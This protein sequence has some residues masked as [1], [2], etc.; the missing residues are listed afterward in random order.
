MLICALVIEEQ[1][2]TPSE[3]TAA[4][5]TAAPPDPVKDDRGRLEIALDAAEMGVWEWF[6]ADNRVIW[7]P[8]IERMHGLAPG[9]FKGQASDT[10]P[11]DRATVEEQVQR[12]L[13]ERTPLRVTYRIIR[14]DQSI[15]WLEAHGQVVLD[16]AGKPERVLGV[17]RDITERRESEVARV[18]LLASEVARADAERQRERLNGIFEGITDAFIV[19]DDEQRVVQANRA[20]AHLS[21]CAPDELI[22]RHIRELPLLRGSSI[23]RVISRA[24]KLRE[25]GVAEDYNAALDR[26]FESNVFP[27]DDGIS[28]YTRDVTLRKRAVELTSR[29]AR[30]SV[31]RA[32]IAFALAEE[33]DLK[34]MLDRCCQALVDNLGVA[35]ARLWTVDESGTTLLLQA[36]AGMYT[37]IDGPHKSVP[38]GSFKIG[39]IASEREPHLTND[40]QNDPRVGNPEWARKEKM[41]S[42]AG[43]PMLVDGE[44]VGVLAMFSRQV[45][46]DDTM[47]ALA[48]IADTIA[49]GVERRRAETELEHRL[50]ELARSN[51]DLEQFAYVASHDLQ[52]PLRMVAS[53]NQLLARR[54]KGKLDP[55]ADEFIGFTV[56]GVTRM[57]R[58]I[59]DLLS[60]SR[61]G[62]GAKQHDKIEL[63]DVLAEATANLAGAIETEHATVTHDPLPQVTGDRGQLVQLLQNLIGNAIKFHGEEPPQIHVIAKRDGAGWKLGVRDNGIGIDPQY[64]ERIFVIFQR[65]HAREDYPGTGIGLAICKKIVERHGG[66]IWVES[67]PKAGS[68]IWFTLARRS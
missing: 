10:H 45:M 53:Y 65:L 57:Q 63:E 20:A 51:A 50:E 7:N 12:A 67:A 19:I 35:F 66:R 59:N 18:R 41:V 26:W 6:L 24:T 46:H 30:H 52:E 8:A 22:G 4:T 56:E 54:Y 3:P 17:I 40:V 58:L 49:Q 23:E 64:F 38:I 55:E 47:S 39:L 14:P 21:R 28:I 34:A 68:T 44:L 5:R 32:E 31:L 11:E 60:Y 61:L 15:R 33:R 1:L 42:F 62:R 2:Q 27:L 29:L 36:S 37:H 43:Y 25:S 16:D 48:G 13:T 9:S